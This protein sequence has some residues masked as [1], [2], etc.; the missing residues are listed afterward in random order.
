MHDIQLGPG[1]GLRLTFDAV[2]F[3]SGPGAHRLAFVYQAEPRALPSAAVAMINGSVRLY[4]GGWVGALQAHELLPISRSAAYPRPVGLTTTL[5]DAQLA[6]IEVARG[7]ED[8][9]L[10]IDVRVTLTGA[11]GMDYPSGAG[12]DHVRLSAA[13]WAHHAERAG[14]LVR[15]PLLVPLPLG[16]AESKRAQAGQ[17]LQLALRDVADGRFDDAVRR[18]RRAMELHTQLDPPPAYKDTSPRDRTLPM[19][20]AALNDSVYQLA[21]G[22]HHADAITADFQY[23]RADAMAVVACVAALMQRTE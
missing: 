12:Q 8:L 22:A 4:R 7:G 5:T 20:F 9:E 2:E 14:A 23:T 19:R 10:L 17:N 16:H 6:G 21:S 3:E 13:D 18:A 1:K 15:V 11:E